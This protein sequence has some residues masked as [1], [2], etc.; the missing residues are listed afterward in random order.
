MKES[1]PPSGDSPV[2]GPSVSRSFGALV[3]ESRTRRPCVLVRHARARCARHGLLGPSQRLDRTSSRT[4]P[5]TDVTAR[6]TRVNVHVCIYFAPHEHMRSTRSPRS[7]TYPR[8][9]RSQA[10]W[11]F[12]ARNP[13]IVDH[14]GGHDAGFVLEMLHGDGSS[15]RGRALASPR[16]ALGRRCSTM[17]SQLA[18][19]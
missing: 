10:S 19:R 3:R 18:W 12:A 6:C 16:L 7:E 2:V 4:V 11:F 1:E 15:P 5:F 17:D 8:S 13:S 9:S 14:P